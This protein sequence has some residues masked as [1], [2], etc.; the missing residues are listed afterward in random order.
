MIAGCAARPAVEAFHPWE[1]PAQTAT[2]TETDGA[3]CQVVNGFLLPEESKPHGLSNTP[4]NAYTIPAGHVTLTTGYYQTRNSGGGAGFTVNLSKPYTA[5]PKTVVFTA[6]PGHTY[7]LEAKTNW[8]MPV[9][10]SEIK[11]DEWDLRVIDTAS[12]TAV[13]ETHDRDAAKAATQ[14]AE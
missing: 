7:A 4:N 1:R 13:A 11:N 8:L 14:P 9:F 6:E 2:I 3:Q 12:K 10:G 5:N